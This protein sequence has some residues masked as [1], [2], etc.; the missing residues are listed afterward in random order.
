MFVLQSPLRLEP[1]AGLDEGTLSL[2]LGQPG[3]ATTTIR[4]LR[5]LVHNANANGLTWEQFDWRYARKKEAKEA[6]ESKKSSSVGGISRPFR[7]FHF[8][9]PADHDHSTPAF[10]ATRRPHCVWKPCPRIDLPFRRDGD[11]L[12]G[13]PCDDHN[14]G[15]DLSGHHSLPVG[16]RTLQAFYLRNPSE[17]EVTW[18]DDRLRHDGE[19]SGTCHAGEPFLHGNDHGDR[20]GN[21]PPCNGRLC[22][23]RPCGVP[24]DDHGDHPGGN[25]RHRAIQR[26]KNAPPLV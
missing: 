5:D 19:E 4:I 17:G 22:R 11:R 14:K 2:G 26:V 18:G 9:W 16:H 1:D 23:G 3:Q 10:N 20:H 8:A 25:C 21:V 13:R 12:C 15:Q 24:H 7:P 6:D